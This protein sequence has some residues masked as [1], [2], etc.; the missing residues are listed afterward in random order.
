MA[1]ATPTQRL[2]SYERRYRELAAQLAEIGLIS[3]GSVTRRYTR[4]ATPGCKCNA[5]PPQPHGPYYQ[6]TTKQNGK[7]VTRRLNAD[8]AK[9]YQQWIDND[10]QM[11][12]LITQMRS[13]RR[14]SRR[15]P[16]HPGPPTPRV[17]TRT[18]GSATW[19]GARRTFL[20]DQ[21]ESR[22]CQRR[23]GRNADVESSCRRC[24]PRRVDVWTWT[25]SAGRAHGGC[26]PRRWRP[27]STPTWRRSPSDA[28]SDGHRLV[29]GNGHARPRV[30][31][32]GAGQIEV[33]APRVNDRRVD[34]ETG[35]RCRF[36]SQIL[37]RGAARARRWPR[38]CR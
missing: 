1:R 23:R 7:T 18:C 15:D 29:V 6:W 16:P 10:R 26:W 33:E 30:I 27:R 17:I 20:V 22:R 2:A 9:L 37:P 5:D 12:R 31:A 28:T 35:E 21:N 38:C 13:D 36:R 24:C 25:R 19:S 32:T 34:A 4:C 8:E 14:Q 3:T 11:R